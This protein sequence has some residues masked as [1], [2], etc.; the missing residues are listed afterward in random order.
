MDLPCSPR[1]PARFLFHFTSHFHPKNEAFWDAVWSKNRP[2]APSANLVRI[3]CRPHRF[4][5]RAPPKGTKIHLKTNL[6]HGPYFLQF[7]LP[8]GTHSGITNEQKWAKGPPGTTPDPLRTLQ[9]PPRNPAGH[10][11]GTVG[12]PM[13][14]FGAPR[15]APDPPMM[16]KGCSRH[17]KRGQND[18]PGTPLGTQN[19]TTF[20]TILK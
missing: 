12:A 11:Q 2:F 18:T 4:M 13:V 17:S 6:F 1:F 16:V 8:F 15:G 3:P 7:L 10:L 20:D 9:E 14:A 19:S 5:V